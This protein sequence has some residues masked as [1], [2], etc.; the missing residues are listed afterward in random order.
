MSVVNLGM[1]KRQRVGLWFVLSLYKIYKPFPIHV[2]D[3]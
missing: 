2:I 1:V 3:E